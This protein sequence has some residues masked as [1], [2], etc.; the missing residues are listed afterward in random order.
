M[1][2]N[3]ALIIGAFALALTASSPAQAKPNNQ[4]AK[5]IC[6]K[7]LRNNYR[8]DG[9]N[10]I[11]TGRVKPG[12]F[13]VQG[14]AQRSGR[15]NRYFSCK[16]KNGRVRKVDFQGWGKKSDAGTAIAAALIG[17]AI[18]GATSKHHD[19]DY[20]QNY[21]VKTSPAFRKNWS[22]SYVPKPGITCFR[23]QRA[24]YKSGKGYNAK[25]TQREF[26]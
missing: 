4:V 26:G 16:V 25:W 22:A 8:A 1:K 17:A 9:F 3:P 18:V 13:K 24:C 20:D 19:H 11:T 5:K 23:G 10:G 15:K 21:T 6:K 12:V 14:Y 7:E 2:I